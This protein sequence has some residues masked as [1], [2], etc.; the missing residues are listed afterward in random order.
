MHQ[1]K[2]GVRKLIVPAGG[3]VTALDPVLQSCGGLWVAHDAGE[4]D[5]ETADA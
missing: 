5:R 3:L 1:L 2:E 4:A